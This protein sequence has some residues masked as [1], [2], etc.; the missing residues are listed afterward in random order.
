M[1]A[2]APRSRDARALA[3]AGFAALLKAV[4]PNRGRLLL[5]GGLVPEHLVHSDEP[6]QGTND[7]DILLDIGLVY[8]RDG[9]DFAW[10]EQALET[11]GFVTSTPNTGWRWL[12]EI[13]GFPIQVEFLVD[14]PD[15]LDQEIALPG[16]ETLGAKNLRGP[17]PALRDVHD[18]VV[19]GERA[20]VTGIGGYLSAKGASAYWRRADKDLYDFAW[21]LVADL[22]SGERRAARAVQRVLDPL[23]ERDRA[24]ALLA[25]CDLF[26]GPD[27]VGA[28]T[29][30]R[31]SIAAGGVDATENLALD[32]VVAVGAFRAELAALL[33]D[34]RIGP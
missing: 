6:H 10:L 2:S 14:V 1:N 11:A 7:V 25:V 28:T 31:L 3:E 32:A 27:A 29:Y 30:A 22:R 8:D 17:G 15:N 34:R 13:S 5:I 24:D 21:V 33:D 12:K 19:A 9:L 18:T 4:G 23:R 26:S 20:T 16:A